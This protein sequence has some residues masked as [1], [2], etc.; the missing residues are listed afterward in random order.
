MPNVKVT[1]RDRR[2][3]LLSH[4]TVCNAPGRLG[5]R[6]SGLCSVRRLV[7][8][9]DPRRSSA[10]SRHH[11]SDQSNTREPKAGL[12]APCV[13]ALWKVP[14]LTTRKP[15]TTCDITSR[16]DKPPILVA[17]T[18]R[19]SHDEERGHGLRLQQRRD[20]APRH[21]L[22]PLVGRLVIPKSGHGSHTRIVSENG[23]FF[24]HRTKAL[25]ATW[26]TRCGSG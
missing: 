1:D 6:G 22:D 7:G 13:Q 8:A 15:G 10:R 18:T 9:G 16:M 24:N 23:R 5:Q 12:S 21:W 11:R 26:A 14:M 19:M 3:G 17:P 4:R 20:C 25:L 2:L